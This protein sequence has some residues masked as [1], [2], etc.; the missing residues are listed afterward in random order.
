MNKATKSLQLRFRSMRVEFVLSASDNLAAPSLSILLPVLSENELKRQVLLLQ[1]LSL[2]R[3]E[4][5]LSA[6][7][8]V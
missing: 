2:V 1:R 3:D 8:T 7:L 4:F 6:S 5:E